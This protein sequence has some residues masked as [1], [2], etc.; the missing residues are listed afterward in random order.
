MGAVSS[1]WKKRLALSLFFKKIDRESLL[2]PIDFE[3]KVAIVTG[4]GHGLGKS[5][6]LFLASRGAKVIV[7]DLGTSEDGTSRS[8]EPAQKVAELIVERGGTAVANFNSVA[9]PDEARKIVDE[10]LRHFGTVDILIN[11]AGILRDRSFSKITHE[12]FEFVL[13]VHLLGAV[14]TTHAAFPVMKRKGYGRIVLTTSIAGLYGN[15]GQTNY[16]TAKMALIGFMNSLKLEGMKFNILVNTVAPLAVTRLAKVSG[17][18]PEEIAG[19]LKTEHVT[20]L[21]AYLCSEACQSSGDILCAGGGYFA[22]A[23]VLEGPG[24]RFNPGDE[25]TP[26]AIADRYASLLNMSGAVPFWDTKEELQVA[27]GPLF[28]QKSHERGKR[29][30][31]L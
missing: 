26:E 11:N 21:V 10:A 16:G 24:V 14:Y 30:G 13:K 2:M 20:P 25:I 1:D 8:Q 31:S 9:D 17:V 6:A 15:F 12:D 7:N 23:Q 28:L 29:D 22:R 19:V 3:G 18:F 5:Y 27:L 4:A